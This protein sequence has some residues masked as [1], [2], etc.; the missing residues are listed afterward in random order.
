MKFLLLILGAAV[1]LAQP[2]HVR[3]TPSHNRLVFEY[4]APSSSACTIEVSESASYAPVVNDVNTTLFTGS[5]SD[6]RTI[7]PNPI[8]QDNHRVF[9]VGT[10]RVELAADSTYQS[11]GIAAATKYFWRLTCGSAVTGVADTGNIPLGNSYPGGVDFLA[12]AFGNLSAPTIDWTDAT[13]V[14][15]HP[16]TGIKHVRLDTPGSNLDSQQINQVFVTPIVDAAAAWTNPTNV[17]DPT[18]YADVTATGSANAL[19][20]PINAGDYAGTSGFSRESIITDIKLTV[21][22]YGANTGSILSTCLS[23]DGG[24][25]CHGNTVDLPTLTASPTTVSYPSSGYPAGIF[26]EWISAGTA[27]PSTAL[28]IAPRSGTATASGTAVTWTGGTHI[29]GDYFSDVQPG[30]HITLNGADKIVA[31]VEDAKHMTL[32]TAGTSGA[33]TI[34]QFGV[35]LWKKSG[36]GVVHVNAAKH[37][38]T[39][40]TISSMPDL[41]QMPLCSQVAVSGG[42]ACVFPGRSGT[43]TNLYWIN[44]TTGA[45]R[46]I[47]RLRCSTGCYD[48]ASGVSDRGIAGDPMAT[49]TPD[50]N[51]PTVWWGLLPTGSGLFKAL[52]KITY[53]GDWSAYVAPGTDGTV[54]NPAV[55]YTNV[56]LAT[57]SLDI[58]TQARALY[59]GDTSKLTIANF[60]NCYFW[61][62]QG[63]YGVIACSQAQDS[64]GFY[65]LFNTSSNLIERVWDTWTTFPNRWNTVHNPPITYGPDYALAMQNAS[66]GWILG[67]TAVTGNG[68]GDT[69]LGINQVSDCAGFGIAAPWV[70]LFNATGVNCAEV[71]ID[72]GDVRQNVSGT[73]FLF[74]NWPHPNQVTYSGYAQLQTLAVGDQLINSTCCNGITSEHMVV[75]KRTGNVLVLRRGYQT[76]S[77]AT[78]RQAHSTGWTPLVLDAYYAGAVHKWLQFSMGV[79]ATDNVLINGA[80]LDIQVNGTTN[81][82]IYAQTTGEVRSGTFAAQIGQ[83]P[84][85]TNGTQY[86]P[87]FAGAP[88]TALIYQA[89][90]GHASCQQHA[91]SAQESRWC[92]DGHPWGPALGGANR[93]WYHQITSCA[94]INTC[95]ASNPATA[96]VYLVGPPTDS[97]GGVLATVDIKKGPI[98]AWAGRNTMFDKGGPS[99]ALGAADT[100]KHCFTYA[101]GECITGSSAGQM[102]MNIPQMYTDGMSPTRN[103]CLGAMDINTP[104]WTPAL[105]IAPWMRQ[106][107]VDV[108]DPTGTYWRNISTF[109]GGHGWT[110]NFVQPR[111]CPDG[112]CM[113][114]IWPWAN[115]NRPTMMLAFL[116]PWPVQDSMNRSTHLPVS[117]GLSGTTGDSIRIQFGYTEYDQGQLPSG[118]P[119]CSPRNE[120]CY[121]DGSG[122]STFDFASET[123]HYTPCTSSCSIIIPKIPDKTLVI[124]EARKNGSVVTLGPIKVR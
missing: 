3:V 90:Q 56:T 75:V 116:P 40:D 53:S 101:A 121:T 93:L 10:P 78:G 47:A 73:G 107:G 6:L 31:S 12:G 91:A 32:T 113:F 46:F 23:A 33:F 39:R 14:Y 87:R 48:A 76:I 85:W 65:A 69:S 16:T 24:Q 119:N 84:N 20:L 28:Y 118:V 68:A 50:P 8:Q 64:L 17:I 105:A 27:P 41:G 81:A 45:A 37:A 122:A 72:A 115:G 58:F 9:I 83:I 26:S 4:D 102:F 120:A 52:W 106:I 63:H 54:D 60:A 18:S 86:Q 15:V 11:R 109:F 97:G 100:S 25:T 95:T 49:V 103:A 112:T 99:S 66:N 36:T 13:K 79:V 114:S 38:Y 19:F 61:S 108:S 21:Q 89:L 2:T 117:I 43:G 111:P 77:S 57:A 88:V 42:F 34:Y 30:A 51:D 74:T 71:T 55:T 67:L 44:K 92:A 104:C 7:D 82:G 96:D 22:A 124:R 5:N 110:D 80:H 94:T 35:R 123:A 62:I 70:T 1:C 98:A 29:V 59:A